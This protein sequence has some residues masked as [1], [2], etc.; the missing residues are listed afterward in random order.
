MSIRPRIRAMS[1][2]QFRAQPAKVKLDQNELP[3]GLTE[4]L[5]AEFLEQVRSIAVN[6]YPDLEATALRTRLSEIFDWPLEGIVVTPGSN[7]L[8]R[9]LVIAAGIEQ[10]VLLPT[11]TFS[12]YRD[13]ARMLGADLIE[14]PMLPGFQLPVEGLLQAMSGRQGVLFVANPAAPTGNLHP[15]AEI[16]DLIAGAGAAWTVVIDEAYCQF[17]DS[18]LSGL[19]RKRGVVSLRTLSKAFGLAGVRLGFALTTPELGREL[20][21]TVIPFSVSEL[22]QAAA[23]TLLDH[24]DVVRQRVAQVVSERRR[25]FSELE[26]MQ[27]VHPFPSV[28][29]FILFRV[30]AA[31]RVLAHLADDGIAVRSQTGPYTPGCLR[32]S[33]GSAH[34]NDAFLAALERVLEEE[35]VDVQDG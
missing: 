29:N 14:V 4:P 3:F 13:Q 9:C 19:A 31:E 22:Q 27:G 7:V 1:G 28:T 8:I 15:L 5:L 32:V 35:T 6:R 21:K 18:D 25:L 10:A 34:E 2:Y 16:E 26:R 30:P 17:A 12:V 11:P 24:P 20:R 23:L 33:V